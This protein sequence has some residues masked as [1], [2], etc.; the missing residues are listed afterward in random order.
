MRYRGQEALIRGG[1][2]A[3]VGLLYAFLFVSFAVSTQTWSLPMEPH[4][5]ATIMAG[6]IAALMYSSMRLAVLVA[7]ILFPYAIISFTTSGGDITLEGQ[8]K[9]MVP[10]GIV[11]GALYGM[12]SKKSRIGH[13]D[14][15][16]LAAFSV[17]FFVAICY[18]LF[19][20]AVGEAP[21]AW[22]V[23]LMCTATGILYSIVVPT[24]IRIYDD[25]LPPFGDGAL[26]GACIAVF[27]SFCF[28]VMAG[29]TN[30]TMTGSLNPTVEHILAL[31]P[32]AVA[33]GVSGA[34]IAGVLSG[35]ALTKWE[36]V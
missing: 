12:L 26:A 27:I 20:Y 9:V 14:A 23:G 10:A 13:A 30:S 24:F 32:A 34:G 5:L 3:F 11:I 21:I 7:V 36:D 18:L 35:L 15:K 4:F 25:L 19:D 28:F 22:V 2:W 6:T 33:G 1:I 29:S 17:S 16:T 8:L 31:L